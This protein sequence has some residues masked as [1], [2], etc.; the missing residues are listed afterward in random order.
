MKKLTLFL[1][2]KDHIDQKVFLSVLGRQ[3]RRFRVRVYSDPEK[4]LDVSGQ[5][6]PHILVM[7]YHD[8]TEED[9]DFIQGLKGRHRKLRAILVTADGLT[10][11]ILDALDRHAIDGYVNKPLNK[12]SLERQFIN[13]ARDMAKVEVTIPFKKESD[14]TSSGE[15]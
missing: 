13:L 12:A 7:G 5:Q 4:L 3:G 2:V 15:G 1:L 9:I 14:Q 11:E 10:G 6:S 8:K